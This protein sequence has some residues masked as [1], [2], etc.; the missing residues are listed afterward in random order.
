MDGYGYAG[1]KMGHQDRI[2]W[3]GTEWDSWLAASDANGRNENNFCIKL[4]I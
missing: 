3:A 1:I 4:R 2:L